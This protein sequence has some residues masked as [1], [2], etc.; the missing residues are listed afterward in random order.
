MSHM[1]QKLKLDVLVA[2]GNVLANEVA[3]VLLEADDSVPQLRLA[4]E[5]AKRWQLVQDD[6]VALLKEGDYAS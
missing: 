4:L 1:Q 3:R 2:E 6:I 5:L